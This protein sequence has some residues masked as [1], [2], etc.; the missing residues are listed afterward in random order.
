[1]AQSAKIKFSLVWAHYPAQATLFE[2]KKHDVKKM[3]RIFED[4][5]HLKPLRT[6]LLCSC[7][8]LKHKEALLVPKYC[9]LTHYLSEKEAQNSFI[10][11]IDLNKIEKIIY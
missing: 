3:E 11:A 9:A 8:E 1:M 7:N 10:S 4:K 2:H 6:L 5:C